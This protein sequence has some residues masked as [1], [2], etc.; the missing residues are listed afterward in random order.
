MLPNCRASLECNWDGD[1][2]VIW[3]ASLFLATRPR[4]SWGRVWI[5]GLYQV[6]LVKRLSMIS[7]VVSGL[8][9]VRVGVVGVVKQSIHYEEF[10]QLWTLLLG[11]NR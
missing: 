1:V 4:C 6:D 9:L 7:M 8:T 2:H 10:I 3:L 5:P 11:L